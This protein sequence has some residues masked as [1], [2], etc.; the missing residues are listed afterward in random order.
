MY[1]TARMPSSCA[2][3]ATPCA[4][5]PA[6]AATIP[7]ARSSAV[8]LAIRTYAPRI[9]NDPARWRFSHFRC[10]GPP[11]F[12]PSG[13]D[14]SS[15]VTRATPCSSLCA[16]LMSSRPTGQIEV[17][18]PAVCH[19]PVRTCRR[20][21]DAAPAGTYNRGTHREVPMSQPAL[22]PRPSPEGRVPRPPG[23]GGAGFVRV[24]VSRRPSDPAE[25][26]GPTSRAHP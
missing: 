17:D 13:R 24:L 8:R 20:D 1:T 9:L 19:G 25:L 4:W 23:P 15:G 11:T 16:A 10:T 5:L 21:D 22:L 14:P 7:A 12:A 3:S 2:A 26:L 6:L 18:M